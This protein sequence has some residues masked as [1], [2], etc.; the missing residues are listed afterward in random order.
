MFGCVGRKLTKAKK[1][2]RSASGHDDNGTCDQMPCQDL[3]CDSRRVGGT[4]LKLPPWGG[5]YLP[6]AERLSSA[7]SAA[8]ALWA[9]SLTQTGDWG[10]CSTARKPLPVA[11]TIKP[12]ACSCCSTAARLDGC[13]CNTHRSP[14]HTPAARN[15][16]DRQKSATLKHAISTKA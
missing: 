15:T 1:L 11:F 3:I 12:R 6:R 7:L 8:L 13:T 10:F 16:A 9:A 5:V 4:L 2:K 14:M